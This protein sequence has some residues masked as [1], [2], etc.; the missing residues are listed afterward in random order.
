MEALPFVAVAAVGPE[1]L[2]LVAC[3]PLPIVGFD[4]NVVFVHFH[5]AKL[6]PSFGFRAV[7]VQM[8]S[9]SIVGRKKFSIGRRLDGIA[10]MR[11]R[12]ENKRLPF[13][14]LMAIAKSPAVASKIASDKVAI[15]SAKMKLEGSLFL[16]QVMKTKMNNLDLNNRSRNRSDNNSRHG[17]G[18]GHGSNS[19]SRIDASWSVPCGCSIVVINIIW[20]V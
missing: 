10:V 14:G 12:D 20:P 2:V 7:K 13:F 17:H 8:P 1:F 3:N 18:H 15:V 5:N 9:S 11:K 4:A 19:N 16:E 6:F